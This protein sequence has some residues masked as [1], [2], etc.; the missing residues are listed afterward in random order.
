MRGIQWCYQAA[1]LKEREIF[2]LYQPFCITLCCRDQSLKWINKKLHF[3]MVWSDWNKCQREVGSSSLLLL[4]FQCN[5]FGIMGRTWLGSVS[6]VDWL[7]H[8]LV[9]PC[10]KHCCL[11]TLCSSASA[12]CFSDVREAN[13]WLSDPCVIP[14]CA[15]VLYTCEVAQ[16]CCKF[17]R[18]KG[19]E[20][21]W[22]S[23]T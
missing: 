11:Q 10:W 2:L 16:L 22:Q 6:S 3:L 7:G 17:W 23:N 18:N 1:D 4:L 13:Q 20:V 9:L 21:P 5:W 15:Q 12:S 14:C 19:I 8:E